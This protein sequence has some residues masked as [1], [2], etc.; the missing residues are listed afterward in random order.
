[1]KYRTNKDLKKHY[2]LQV[3]NKMRCY[4]DT[5]IEKKAIRINKKKSEASER[6]GEVLDTIVHETMHAKHPQMHERTVRKKTKVLVKKLNK[7]QKQG[8][9]KLFA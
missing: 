7:R 6:K 9:Y 2:K 1:M 4:G 8:Y 3:D 5:D